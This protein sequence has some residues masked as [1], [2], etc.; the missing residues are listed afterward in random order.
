MNTALVMYKDY[1]RRSVCDILSPRTVFTPGSGTWGLQGIVRVSS[2]ANSFVFF[3]TYG[4]EVSGH[5][6]SEPISPDG[7]IEWQSQPRQSLQSPMIR[8]FINHDDTVDHIYLFLRTSPRKLYTYLGNL[9]YLS[10][11]GV[12]SHKS[13]I[14]VKFKWRILD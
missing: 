10:H 12:L 14:P 13:N 6:F 4:R 8:Q 1:S 5:Q 3:V 11:D 7:V 9:K 2:N